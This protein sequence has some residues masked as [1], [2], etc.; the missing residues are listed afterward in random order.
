[1]QRSVALLVTGASSSIHEWKKRFLFISYST[2]DDWDL[3][4]W[5]RPEASSLKAI[6]LSAKEK[7]GLKD[8]QEYKATHLEE[9]L[10]D[11]SLLSTGLYPNESEVSGVVYTF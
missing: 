4:K 11:E 6:E 10:S 1:M 8:L 9:L 2:V 7:K 5:V 3:P